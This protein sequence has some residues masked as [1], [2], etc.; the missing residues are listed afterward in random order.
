MVSCATR[1]TC[2]RVCLAHDGR[3]MDM[4]TAPE[5]LSSQ[6]ACPLSIVAAL[7]Q[8]ATSGVPLWQLLAARFNPHE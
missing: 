7:S 2:Q 3:N 1:T 8:A 4:W 5:T 6:G